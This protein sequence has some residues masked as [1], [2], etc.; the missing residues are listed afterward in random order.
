MKEKIKEAMSDMLIKNTRCDFT[1]VRSYGQFY[2]KNISKLDAYTLAYNLSKIGN[3]ECYMSPDGVKAASPVFTVIDGVV[4]LSGQVIDEN[5][6]KPTPKEV[7]CAWAMETNKV[8]KNIKMMTTYNRISKY[9]DENIDECMTF[10]KENSL[11]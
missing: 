7:Y 2:E 1:F 8:T 11:I 5:K 10:L 3:I 6:E 4:S 9:W